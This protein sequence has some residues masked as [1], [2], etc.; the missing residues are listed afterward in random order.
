MN[1]QHIVASIF[2]LILL[3]APLQASAGTCSP[4]ACANIGRKTA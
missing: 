3:L 2:A 1:Y 4:L